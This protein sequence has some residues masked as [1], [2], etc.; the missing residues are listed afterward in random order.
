MREKKP[1]RIGMGRQAR[2]ARRFAKTRTPKNAVDTATLTGRECVVF[3]AKTI[4]YFFCS[5]RRTSATLFPDFNAAS[6]QTRNRKSDQTSRERC[7]S[8]SCCRATTRG[9][10]A[11]ARSAKCSGQSP[12]SA[13]LV[14][15]IVRRAV[16]M[17]AMK[18]RT[19]S[20]K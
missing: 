16:L 6:D 4:Q 2:P 14:H 5:Y 12:E 18:F 11:R 17:L 15:E 9:L 7:A 20:S 13:D 3:L 19:G 10:Q 1:I 8:I